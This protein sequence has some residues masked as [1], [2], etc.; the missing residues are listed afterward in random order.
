[1]DPDVTQVRYEH[2]SR[3][4][5]GSVTTITTVYVTYLGD[6][7][8]SVTERV[9]CYQDSTIIPDYRSRGTTVTGRRAPLSFHVPRDRHSMEH[10][11]VKRFGFKIV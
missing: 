3:S 2:E 11:L 10:D 9:E 6:R 1:M 5:F 8:S 4:A 7:V